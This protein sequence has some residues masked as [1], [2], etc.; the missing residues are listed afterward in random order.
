MRTW[1]S[2][3]VCGPVGD[4]GHGS[5][6]DA[7]WASPSEGVFLVACGFSPEPAPFR[8]D[9]AQAA[10]E[11]AR[12]GF[13]SAWATGD[14]PVEA[15]LRAGFAAADARV[16]EVA[17][18]PQG[19]GG[20]WTGT[21][22]MAVLAADGEHV[23]LAHIGTCRVYRSVNGAWQVHT[24]DHTFADD[25]RFAELPQADRLVSRRLGFN[26]CPGPSFVREPRGHA[27]FL[28]TTPALARGLGMRPART[29][30][31]PEAALAELLK[32]ARRPAG[33]DG[34]WRTA[35]VAR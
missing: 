19:D 9:L 16:R 11:A 4:E 30:D 22:E 35:I 2:D 8:T 23:W 24:R 33:V 6:A 28:L 20:Q 1:Q 13:R 12:D 7:V 34:W 21:A 26:E 29:A 17:A 18:R 31:D 27:A 3:S 25:P 14:G 15:R 10:A 5:S 32:A